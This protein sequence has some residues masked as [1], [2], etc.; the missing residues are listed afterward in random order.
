M[1]TDEIA[2]YTRNILDDPNAVFLPNPLL[3]IFLNRAYAEFR[4][5]LPTEAKEIRFQPAA[6]VNVP[7]LNLDNVMFG[8][9]PTQSRCQEMTRVQFVDPV[10]S[11]FLGLLTPMPTFEALAPVNSNGWLSAQTGGQARWWL[12]GRMLRFSSALTATIQIF[13]IPDANTFTTANIVPAAGAYLDDFDQFHD[14]IAVMAAKHYAMKDGAMQAPIMQQL[15]ILKGEMEQHFAE[16]RS[17]QGS[18]YV[19]DDGGGYW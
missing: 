2:S 11:A 18:R 9:T 8:T 14:L 16:T 1:L 3:A 5:I 10:T 19:H 12:D 6:L 15:S 7:Q 13:Y 4:R 17:G